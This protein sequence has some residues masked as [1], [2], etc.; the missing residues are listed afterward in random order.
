MDVNEMGKVCLTDALPRRILHVGLETLTHFTKYQVPDRPIFGASPVFR[1]TDT[2][3]TK[4]GHP[5][6]ELE[7][8]LV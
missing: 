3:L 4:A 1:D 2:A 6:C 5:V 8:E 7:L